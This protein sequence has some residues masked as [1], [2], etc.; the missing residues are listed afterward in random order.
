MSHEPLRFYQPSLEDM[1]KHPVTIFSGKLKFRSGLIAERY[2]VVGRISYYPF[3]PKTTN[4]AMSQTALCCI[5]KRTV[6]FSRR[7]C[8]FTV[9]SL[10]CR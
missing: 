4:A 9:K 7:L 3:D 2:L 8:P 10:I 1:A 6:V 5:V